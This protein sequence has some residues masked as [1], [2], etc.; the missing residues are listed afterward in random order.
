M[1]PSPV[2]AFLLLVL[3]VAAMCVGGLLYAA[4]PPRDVRVFPDTASA[5]LVIPRE[6]PS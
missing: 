4:G 2:P 5:V 6:V 3:V 1:N